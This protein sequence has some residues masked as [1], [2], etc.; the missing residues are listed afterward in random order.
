MHLSRRLKPRRFSDL[1]AQISLFRPGPVRGDL[2]TPYVLR[3]Q[4]REQYSVPLPE[5][6][7]VLRST[8]GVLIFQEQVL[9]IACVVAGF[10]LAEETRSGAP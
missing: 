4:G 7:P 1:V 6:G 2:V 8:Y 9:E 5:L 3:R 10:S